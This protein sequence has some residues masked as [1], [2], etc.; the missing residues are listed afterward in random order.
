MTTNGI[1]HDIYDIFYAS[2][3][4]N[5]GPNGPI[6]PGDYLARHF[7]CDASLA[8]DMMELDNSYDVEGLSQ[9]LSPHHDDK[10]VNNTTLCGRKLTKY[11]KRTNK[12]W[13]R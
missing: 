4:D 3:R 12:S 2:L 10:Y 7:C 8:L 6:G 11:Y 9:T 13:K 5:V 1:V